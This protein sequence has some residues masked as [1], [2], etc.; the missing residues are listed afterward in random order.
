MD[1]FGADWK[2]Y[3][4]KIEKHWR[5]LITNDDLVLIAGD[6]SWAMNL[7]EAMPDLNWIAALPGTKLMCK[8]NHDYWWP[9]A[10]KLAKAL[11]PSIKFIYNNVFNWNGV[12]IGGT[13]LWDSKEYSFG[14]FI[15]FKPGKQKE[16]P[17]KDFEIEEKIFLR[18]LERLKYSLGQLDPNAH[19]RIAMVHYPPIGNDLKPSRASVI[20]EHYKI[21]YCIF[22]H[23]HSLKKGVQLFGEARGIKYILTSCDYLNFI[24]IKVT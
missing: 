13:R 6:I 8:G 9:S 7:D 14:E 22:G 2:D 10:S 5:L 4:D 12:S 23:L 1:L 17:P 24:P 19:T 15:D 16:K 11:P 21:D 18:E 20:L 3:T